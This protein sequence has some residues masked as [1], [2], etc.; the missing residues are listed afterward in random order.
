MK[1]VIYFIVKPSHC[2]T[3]EKYTY[4]YAG[5][6]LP[7]GVIPFYLLNI[8]PKCKDGVVIMIDV[9]SVHKG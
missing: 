3:L 1:F 4:P 9:I 7:E 6:I 2:V 5:I 8:L